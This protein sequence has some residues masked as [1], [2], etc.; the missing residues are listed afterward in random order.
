M[1]FLIVINRLFILMLFGN[2]GNGKNLCKIRIGTHYPLYRKLFIYN[3]PDTYGFIFLNVPIFSAVR[4]QIAQWGRQLT[5]WHDLSICLKRLEK[6]QS[7]DSLLNDKFEQKCILNNIYKRPSVIS[8]HLSIPFNT[9]YK[10]KYLLKVLLI[11]N[12]I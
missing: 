9:K 6:K 2:Y 3:C 10:F 8:I 12:N 4:Y 5:K 1:L 7:K 11:L